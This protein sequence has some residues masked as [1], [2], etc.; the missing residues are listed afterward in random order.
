MSDPSTER[1]H[2][3]SPGEPYLEPSQEPPQ[4]RSPDHLP[5]RSPEP[6][7]ERSLLASVVTDPGHLPEIL[8]GF[9][10]RRLGPA[11]P[12]TVD[13]LRRDRPGA[14]EAELRAVVVARGR[15][16]VVAEGSVVGG[17]FLVLIPLAF[18][19]A[20]LRQARTILELAALSGRD[21]TAAARRAE[22]LVIQGVYGDTRQAQEALTRQD[23]RGDRQDR[24]ADAPP[25]RRRRRTALWRVTVRMA[26]LLG[27]LAPGE[28][29]DGGDGGEGTARRLRRIAVQV[30]RW[31]LLGTVFLVGL[32]APLVW[33]PYMAQVYRRADAR[34]TARVLAYYVDGPVPVPARRVSR[35]EP[36]VVAA[37]LRALLSLLV[38]LVLTAMT[39]LT[40]LRIADSRW[41]VLG[42][43]LAAASV[44]V[45]GLWYRRHRRRHGSPFRRHGQRR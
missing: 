7:L 27:L 12:G 26:H 30:W 8:A 45:G 39:F 18:C 15:R 43:V 40:G 34:L 4:E 33:L 9:A 29:S 31:L 42:I 2:G 3:A 37:A 14:T 38:P 1:G 22:L 24:A 28:E 13:R 5:D 10:V 44:A 19:A 41:P 16:A 23:G 21:P 36:D 25:A 6:S 11:V 20:L 17:P 32:V 35:L